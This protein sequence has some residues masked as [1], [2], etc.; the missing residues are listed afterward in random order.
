[1]AKTIYL[2]SILSNIKTV[3][4]LTFIFSSWFFVLVITLMCLSNGGWGCGEIN[5]YSKSAKLL[6]IITLVSIV[7]LALIPSKSEMYEMTTTQD[8]QMQEIYSMTK[9]ELGEGIDY[10]FERIEVFTEEGKNGK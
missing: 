10:M 1:M 5:S 2:I 6:G 3:A 4:L 9:E 7:I 8:Y